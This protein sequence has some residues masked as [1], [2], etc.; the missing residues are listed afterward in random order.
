MLIAS[1]VPYCHNI[2]KS[3]LHLGCNST[4]PFGLSMS[5]VYIAANRE[6]IEQRRK[7]LRRYLTL[8]ARHP[9]MHDDKLVQF[10]L[11]FS[12]SVCITFIDCLTFDQVAVYVISNCF[13]KKIA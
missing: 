6:F 10:F 9:L 7:A 3:L 12:G 4:G 2:F 1:I 8:I 13:E 11:S 5:L